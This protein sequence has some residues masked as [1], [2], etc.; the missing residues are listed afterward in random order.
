MKKLN[1]LEND[2]S[3]MNQRELMEFLTNKRCGDEI[4]KNLIRFLFKKILVN[5]KCI[6]NLFIKNHKNLNEGIDVDFFDYL[7]LHTFNSNPYNLSECEVKMIVELV[8]I[9]VNQ[10]GMIDE[11][12]N[13]IKK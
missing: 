6:T 1:K 10:L 7:Y 8:D 13:Y 12:R 3:V 11:I 9:S 5:H 2:S 4:P